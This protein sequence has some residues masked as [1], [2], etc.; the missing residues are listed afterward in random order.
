MKPADSRSSLCLMRPCRAVH[1]AE[2]RFGIWLRRFLRTL[3]LAGALVP[4]APRASPGRVDPFFDTSSGVDQPV[5]ILGVQASGHIVILGTFTDSD[6]I[7][8]HRMAR[9]H[10]DGRLDQ[11]LKVEVDPVAPL[12]TFALLPDGRM[13]IAGR[14]TASDGVARRGLARLL[15]TGDLDLAFASTHLVA[16]R[17]RLQG[18]GR[19]LA[20][21][22]D[23]GGLIRLNENGSIDPEFH[24]GIDP[25]GLTLWGLFP[26]GRILLSRT[27][28]ED[29]VP[30]VDLIRLKANGDLDPTFVI[31]PLGAVGSY[32]V[33]FA[34][35]PDGKIVFGGGPKSPAWGVVR[36]NADGTPDPV[37]DT[38]KAESRDTIDD[39]WLKVITTGPDG[40]V[41]L[42]GAIETKHPDFMGGDDAYE[43]GYVRRLEGRQGKE[44]RSFQVE[45][46]AGWPGRPSSVHQILVQPDGQLLVSGVFSAINGATRRYLVRLD[47]AGRLDAGFNANQGA[48]APVHAVLLLQDGSALVGGQARESAGMLGRPLVQLKPD[49]SPNPNFEAVFPTKDSSDVVVT[50]L[51]R[52]RD[53]KIL[54]G[55]VDQGLLR[56][57][58]NGSRDTT[59]VSGIVPAEEY[60]IL[61]QPDGRILVGAGG[62]F[63]LSDASFLRGGVVRLHEDGSLDSSFNECAEVDGPILAIVQYSDGRVLIGG[64]FDRVAGEPRKGVARLDAMG[65]LDLTFDVG[66]GPDGPIRCL[67][68]QQDGQLLVGGM[69]R[70]FSGL[71]RPGLVRLHADGRLDH[72]FDARIVF[73]EGTSLPR[74][75]SLCVQPD[76]RILV[77][78]SF[79]RVGALSRRN[80]ARLLPGGS[81][82]LEFETGRGVEG[83]VMALALRDDGRVIVGGK[84]RAVGGAPRQHVAQLL[85]RPE[86]EVHL[87][88]LRWVEGRLVFD[89]ASV[90]PRVGVVETSTNL[91]DWTRTQA[92]PVEL[93]PV[94]VTA[95]GSAL[96]PH[97]FYRVSWD[98]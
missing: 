7:T 31:R 85:G 82:D 49:G 19:I 83:E 53:D 54:V 92:L 42:G 80:V 37:F 52:Q 75:Q 6:G 94:Q 65:H 38:G 45:L 96:M 44:D 57:H 27:T 36:L 30:Q 15:P 48:D 95:P 35:Q 10:A 22:A 72:T 9:L 41:Y 89:L 33:P 64:E 78:G 84:F 93:S 58:S 39:Y 29:A 91:V 23:G 51:I 24:L 81:P 88:P 13:L 74:I 20:E 3:A 77:A 87:G 98:P 76:G 17:I 50:S 25:A 34:I 60:R 40:T 8:H 70:V 21:M 5:R 16:R 11:A 79:D 90:T 32:A 56:L 47:A 61:L 12:D 67:A 26:D 46:S 28:I 68:V 2:Y 43:Q 4:A 59:F 69:F 18:D 66:V 62:F 55:V 1:R 97:Q 86:N 71:S 63:R 14:F 73:D